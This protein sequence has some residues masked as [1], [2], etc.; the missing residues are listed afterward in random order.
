MKSIGMKK[1]TTV[2]NNL[3]RTLRA[4]RKFATKN[5]MR[6]SDDQLAKLRIENTGEMETIIS[7]CRA[8]YDSLQQEKRFFKPIPK[9]NP[10]WTDQTYEMWDYMEL[11]QKTIVHNFWRARFF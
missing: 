7:Q 4:F 6:Y 9:Y 3:N 5:S 2:R 10:N 1:I 11:E 8:D